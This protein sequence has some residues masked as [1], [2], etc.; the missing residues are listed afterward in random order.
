M[1]NS[2]LVICQQL[3]TNQAEFQSLLDIVCC[4]YDQNKCY[5]LFVA[6]SSDKPLVVVIVVLLLSMLARS[7][8]KVQDESVYVVCVFNVGVSAS[9]R[10][11]LETLLQYDFLLE[12]HFACI[13]SRAVVFF[14]VK[15]PNKIRN[16]YIVSI[17]R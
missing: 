12:F 14:T 13:C 6:V 17:Y 4:L 15:N 7:Y 9:S 3:M 1:E 2:A 11:S 16:V 10:S 5:L 8:W